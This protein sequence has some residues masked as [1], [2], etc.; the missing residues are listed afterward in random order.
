M[1]LTFD[2]YDTLVDMQSITDCIQQIATAHQVDPQQAAFLYSTYEDRLMYGE[3][4]RPYPEL[5]QQNLAYMDMELRTGQLFQN[6]VETVFEAYR[7][8]KPHPEVVATLKTLLA[9]GHQ[10]YIMSNTDPIFMD[11]NLDQLE[12]AVTD[13]ILTKDTHCYKPNL[14]FFKYVANK[15]DFAHH[16]HTHIAMGYWWDMVPCQTLGW[17]RIWIN[18]EGLTAMPKY[19]PTVT[20]PDLTQVPAVISKL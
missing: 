16:D 10:I 6:H 1:I 17:R 5:I 2:C 8:L 12:H 3:A 14:Q 20:L 11:H 4:F 9:Q 13:V 18:R 7:Q 15:L 19:Q